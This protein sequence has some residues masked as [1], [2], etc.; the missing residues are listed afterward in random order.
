M[1]SLTYS[2]TLQSSLKALIWLARIGSGSVSGPRSCQQL[3][4]RRLSPVSTASLIS[5]STW[6]YPHLLTSQPHYLV[7]DVLE[8][9]VLCEGAA[10]N[11][12]KA[13]LITLMRRYKRHIT[14]GV[15]TRT[16]AL[17]VLG[18]QSTSWLKE[19]NHL[20]CFKCLVLV[21]YLFNL[22]AFHSHPFLLMESK[23][24]KQNALDYQK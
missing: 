14:D 5:N 22:W 13:C 9:W 19:V 23:L 12:L 15:A 17:D 1:Q 6:Y 21:I 3:H 18:L 20:V 16:I 10:D 7:T 2:R 24:V 11:L 4:K 8:M